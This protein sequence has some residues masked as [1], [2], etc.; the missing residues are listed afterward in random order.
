MNNN[1]KANFNEMQIDLFSNIT[2]DT[3]DIDNKDIDNKG[4]IEKTIKNDEISPLAFTARPKSKTEFVGYELLLKKFPFLKLSN[5]PSF[6]IYGP[7]G[8]GK[9]TLAN[10]IALERKLHFYPFSAVLGSVVELKKIMEEARL[11]TL[12]SGKMPLIFIDEIQRFNKDQQD[13][14]LPGVEAGNFILVGATTENPK[15]SLNNALISRLN[16]VELK[17][18][19]DS[20]LL[21]I[22]KNVT[23]KQK[24][25]NFPVEILK[26]IV[27]SA[28]GDARRALNFLEIIFKS[29]IGI[30]SS[31]H[32]DL[33]EI[34]TT[35]LK[36][37]RTYDKDQNRHYDVIS[38]FIKSMRG[39][40]PD[41]ALLWFAVMLDGGEDP[42][43]IARRMIIFASEDIG[44]ADP[45]ALILATSTLE[46]VKNIGMP[47]AR[48]NLA[49]A[50]TYLA[51]T[52]KSNANYVGIN[53]AMKFV[54]EHSTI[55]VPNNIKTHPQNYKYPHNF[56]QHFVKENYNGFSNKINEGDS[57][58]F[59]NFYRPTEFGREKFLKERLDNLWRK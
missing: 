28:D 59:P 55:E 35:I 24:Y 26:L 6:V 22:L 18:L 9:T 13:A 51:S 11:I 41:S 33:Q 23:I 46:A 53:E 36:N 50:V 15:Y 42:L 32:Y 3:E 12:R 8:T 25:P 29:N 54:E 56:P 34:K 1:N 39:S 20:D 30:D 40:D 19:N 21:S 5:L 10:L 45:M 4:I 44:N 37:N 43:F 58:S 47:E 17:K 31:K 49:Q 38:A 57:F 14:L 27:E 48:I 2:H 7:P 16:F 52:F